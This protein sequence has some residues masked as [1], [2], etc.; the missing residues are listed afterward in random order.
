[1]GDAQMKCIGKIIQAPKT[2]PFFLLLSTTRG[3]HILKISYS[4]VYIRYSEKKVE[5]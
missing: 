5:F 3:A 1:M 2:W 4:S